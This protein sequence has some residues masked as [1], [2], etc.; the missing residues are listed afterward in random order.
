MG[1]AV[2]TVEVLFIGDSLVEFF[3]WQ[4]R[5]PAH[6]VANLGVAG[7]PVE[8]LL[9]RAERVAAEHPSPDMAFVMSGINNVAM[10]ET[11]FHEAYRRL[12][13]RLRA[14]W[15]GARVFVLSLLPVL[16][17]W[18]PDSAI[19]EANEALMRVAGQEGAEYVDLYSR[20]AAGGGPG[21]YL[22]SDGVHLNEEGY[23]LWAREVEDIIEAGG[24]KGAY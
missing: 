7:E 5:F 19:R 17:G 24:A 9:A 21:R 13:K 10:E 20:F 23:A 1:Q 22:L 14:A 16:L 2:Q 4:G 12:L 6:R 11:G 3:D 8:G 15:P 18:V